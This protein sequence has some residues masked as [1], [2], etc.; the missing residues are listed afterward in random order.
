MAIW[1]NLPFEVML[2]IY[3]YLPSQ[4]RFSLSLT[5]KQF[6][7]LLM[8][9][10][11]WH[12]THFQV[13]IR[14]K[15]SK[16][17][18]PDKVLNALRSLT[19]DFSDP[20]KPDARCNLRMRR[21][22]TSLERVG[23]NS[24]ESMSI[25]S[26]NVN[27]KNLNHLKTVFEFQRKLKHFSLYRFGI[28][29]SCVAEL[30]TRVLMNC[31]DKLERLEVRDEVFDIVERD[32]LRLPEVLSRL[33]RLSELSVSYEFISD[34]LL[35]RLPR[36]LQ[37]IRI[38]STT[39][40]GNV[41]DI[42][43]DLSQSWHS[44]TAR[45]PTLRVEYHISEIYDVVYLMNIIPGEVPL[46][47]LYWQS[48]RYNI[49]RNWQTNRYNIK[50]NTAGCFKYIME[51]FHNLLELHINVCVN[52]FIEKELATTLERFP[53]LETFSICQKPRTKS[54]SVEDLQQAL[55]NMLARCP[56][57]RLTNTSITITHRFK[58]SVNVITVKDW[59][60]SVEDVAH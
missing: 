20:E 18:T 49:K 34:A 7:S 58:D 60:A 59:T 55:G 12:G 53:V 5:C 35:S 57:R 9:P 19:V 45:L 36:T 21:I 2:L 1:T 43:E 3:C 38:W 29:Y 23:N 41:D 17:R 50:R 10:K 8:H 24:L 42:D 44:L 25:I 13:N 46:S 22:L 54:F 26:L 28:C 15:E 56:N 14:N 47:C 30:L 11:I 6:L 27:M 32:K 4:D 51:N 16:L 31:A 39:V 48:K 40:D 33:M 37:I 52:L